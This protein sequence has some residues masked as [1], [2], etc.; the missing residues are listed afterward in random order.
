MTKK[1][2][3][4]LGLTVPLLLLTLFC[5]CG[6]EDRTD[7]PSGDIPS[8]QTEESPVTEVSGE[9]DASSTE[10]LTIEDTSGEKDTFTLTIRVK[11]I[12][13]M[14]FGMFSMID[15]VTGKQENLNAIADREILTLGG[16]YVVLALVYVFFEKVI[17]N[18]RP[19][20]MEGETEAEAS[21]PSSHTMLV[22]V[23]MGS[24][25]MLLG[26]YIKDE[27]IRR[28]LKIVFYLVIAVTV[29]GRLFSGVHWLTDI[30]GGV[31]IS[32]CLLSIFAILLPK[33]ED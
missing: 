17:I 22:C 28:V 7:L 6:P 23:V 4:Q 1:R 2:F 31:L 21:F 14:S 20:I 27:K 30:L 13:G 15:P 18:Y 32:I 16:L 19:I 33:R 5:G 24:A 29:L 10:E 9:T 11:N 25:I 26:R 3:L 12:C 8:S